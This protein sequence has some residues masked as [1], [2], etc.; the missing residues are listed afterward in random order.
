MSNSSSPFEPGASV[1]AYLR[2]SPGRQQDLSVGRQEAVIRQWC[3]EN[4]II[5]R[6]IF[7][8][9][10]KS[11][12]STAGRVQFD[13]LVK[14]LEN[15]ASENGIVFWEYS[16]LARDYD[17]AQFYLSKMRRQGYILYSLSDNVPPGSVGKVVESLYL[18]AAED[19][20]ERLGERVKSGMHYIASVHKC[21]PSGRAPLG[22]QF[23]KV[24]IGKRRDGTMHTGR[25][26][27]PDPTT[28]P[29]VRRAFAMRAAGASHKEI[30]DYLGYYR[31]GGGL[32]AMLS[33]PLYI[34]IFEYGGMRVEGFCEP[35]V[36]IVTWQAVQ[37]IHQESAERANIHHP[38][39][40][41]SIYL[42]S[43]LV[44]CANCNGALVGLR[45]RKYAYYRCVNT[46]GTSITDC[47]SKRYI[48]ARNLE[49]RVIT[50]LLDLIDRPQVLHDI[51]IEQERNR[52]VGD[53]ER[54][55]ELDRK[56][57]EL[58][59]TQKG[60]LNILGAIREGG[61]NVRG[62][63][64]ELKRLEEQEAELQE[65]VANLEMSQPIEMVIPD[66]DLL[67][68]ELRAAIKN[69]ERRKLQLLLR[70]MV[71]LIRVSQEK[72]EIK[73]EIYYV[74]GAEGVVAL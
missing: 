64:M 10:N 47:S 24:V 67:A 27:V 21:Y 61:E 58:K 6:R 74:L 63:V 15:G 33:N 71:R 13:A 38:R 28:A 69:A 1:I 31:S 54:Q 34:G 46:R 44:R 66:L 30:L 20:R 4:G 19:E 39:R 73:G 52:Q 49:D 17:D 70:S 36:D 45:M 3:A 8:D 14:Y 25:R 42:L 35:L 7:S 48:P 57:A 32:S 22:Y 2:A 16:R 18:W 12:G 37:R 72:K 59:E 9:D 50:R 55:S 60:M 23:E 68:G 29:L 26:L 65:K 43:G 40:A 62:L 11:G 41:T 53:I 5:L 51:M 56:R